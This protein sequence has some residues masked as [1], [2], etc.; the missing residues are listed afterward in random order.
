MIAVHRSP[1]VSVGA[2]G[3]YPRIELGRQTTSPIRLVV[4]PRSLLLAQGGR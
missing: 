4:G 2:A 1:S 3:T